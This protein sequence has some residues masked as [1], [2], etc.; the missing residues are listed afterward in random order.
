MNS[1]EQPGDKETKGSDWKPNA[2]K[3]LSHPMGFV[4]V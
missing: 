4:Q 3:V 2:N 1:L